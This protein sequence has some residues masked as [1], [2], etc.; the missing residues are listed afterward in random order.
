MHAYW[1]YLTL[2][3]NLIDSYLSV[4]L[5]QTAVDVDSNIGDYDMHGE[6]G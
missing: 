2:T 5:L 1:S 3:L 4:L 6:E